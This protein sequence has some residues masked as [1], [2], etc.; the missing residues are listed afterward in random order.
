MQTF[1]LPV[2]STVGYIKSP[3]IFRVVSSHSLYS[4]VIILTSSKG[5]KKKKKFNFLLELTSDYVVL[6]THLRVFNRQAQRAIKVSDIK[7]IEG[8]G[9]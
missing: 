2:P 7:D 4:F 8:R 3:P 5:K 1:K 6:Y 9:S